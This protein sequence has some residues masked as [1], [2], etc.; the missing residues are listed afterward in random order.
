MLISYIKLRF[1]RPI[2]VNRP[3]VIENRLA[4]AWTVA[5]S[6]TKISAMTPAKGAF[7][8]IEVLSVSI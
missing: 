3:G 6:S 8:G 5:P 7:T 2:F 4:P 1:E